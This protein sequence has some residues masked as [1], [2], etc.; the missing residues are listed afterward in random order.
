MYL[1]IIV[2]QIL[3]PFARGVRYF[4]TLDLDSIILDFNKLAEAHMLKILNWTIASEEK[5]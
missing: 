2:K 4:S 3:L 1:E 5:L